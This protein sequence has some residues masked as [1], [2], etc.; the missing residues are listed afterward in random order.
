MGYIPHVESHKIM[1]LVDIL[2]MPYQ[3]KVSI[4]DNFRDTARWMSPMKMFEYM[5]SGVPIISSDL[6]V[7]KE[8]LHNESNALLVEPNEADAWI[9]A[10]LRLIEDTKLASRISLQALDDYKTHYTWEIRAKKI[11][12]AAQELW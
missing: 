2:L 8:V 4:G 10:V 7:L 6:P 3:H 1:K 12:K 5:A 11:I 9:K